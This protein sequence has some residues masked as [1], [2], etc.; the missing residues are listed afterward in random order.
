MSDYAKVPTMPL[1]A[2]E[3]FAG[4]RKTTPPP[5]SYDQSH[6][7]GQPTSTPAS[8][9]SAGS[10]RPRR[11]TAKKRTYADMVEGDL[12][13]DDYSDESLSPR[14]AART[15]AT[16]RKTGRKGAHKLSPEDERLE[17]NRQSARDCRRRKKAYISTLEAKVAKYETSEELRRAELE[18]T[19]AQLSEL[20][21]HYDTL[22]LKVNVGRC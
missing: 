13:D 3:D 16:G 8:P 19:R 7:L 6:A 17:K 1:V 9:R 21:K 15:S 12:S 10:S 4:L 5:L 20:R 11:A 18:R 2:D 14:P 22:L